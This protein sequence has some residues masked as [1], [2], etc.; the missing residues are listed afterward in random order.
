MLIRYILQPLLF[1]ITHY[2]LLY[3]KVPVSDL[4]PAETNNYRR[5]PLLYT[6]LA[7]V[8]CFFML[9]TS[10][11][12]G[13]AAIALWALASQ[14]AVFILLEKDTSLPKEELSS[15][16][17]LLERVSSRVLLILTVF[18][19]ALSRGTPFVLELGDP[20]HF[21][22]VAVAE[23]LFWIA[24]IVLV[25]TFEPSVIE[26]LIKHLQKHR[27]ARTDMALLHYPTHTAL[28]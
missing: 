16:L 11:T 17:A 2:G 25:K 24:F 18:V 22:P 8:F 21:L 12:T 7:A 3:L 23:A 5:L 14:A 26:F 10:I 13:N 1:S 4:V 6:A 27:H 28:F 19:I 15:S 9:P 20:G